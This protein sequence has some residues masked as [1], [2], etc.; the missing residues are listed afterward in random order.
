VSFPLD[1]HVGHQVDAL[2]ESNGVKPQI[3]LIG[4]FVLTV[5]EFVAAGLGVSLVHPILVS[6][7]RHRLAVRRFKPDVF[8]SVALCRSADSRNDQLVDI[9]VQKFRETA[10]EVSREMLNSSPARRRRI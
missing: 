9:L 2:F 1:S 5:C 7:F 8:D 3:V 4:N 10:N 6:E